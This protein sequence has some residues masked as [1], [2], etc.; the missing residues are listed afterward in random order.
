M[1]YYFQNANAA[2]SRMNEN[3]MGKCIISSQRRHEIRSKTQ[4]GKLILNCDSTS[5]LGRL[6]KKNEV[7]ANRKFYI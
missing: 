6:E 3:P 1:E 2:N 4:M 7:R 5:S